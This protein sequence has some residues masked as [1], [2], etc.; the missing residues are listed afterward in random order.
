MKKKVMIIDLDG[1][2]CD[3]SKRKHYVEGAKKD[4]KSFYEEMDQDDIRA[5]IWAEIKARSEK[6]GAGIVFI[7]GRPEEYRYTTEF[8]LEEHDIKPFRDFGALLMRQEA[9]H[10]EDTIVKSELFDN[11]L[12]EYDVECAYD[13][14]PKVIR[15]WKERGFE[16]IDVGDGV[17]F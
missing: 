10:R 5:D 6:S 13:D 17:E 4:F 12:S 14:R 3:S 8:W 11:Y 15:M 1:T 2:I 9:D 7:T 16:V